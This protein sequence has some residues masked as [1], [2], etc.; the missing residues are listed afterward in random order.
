MP[1][2]AD[3]DA[4]ELNKVIVAMTSKMW[5]PVEKREDDKFEWDPENPSVICAPVQLIAVYRNS[6]G[7]AVIRQ[8]EDMNAG[9]DGDQHVIVDRRDIPALVERLKQIYEG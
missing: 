1:K 6:W 9:D 3:I 7:Q 4:Y 5:C 2:L 8:Q